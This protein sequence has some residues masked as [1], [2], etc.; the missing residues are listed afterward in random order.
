MS[1]AI[2]CVLFLIILTPLHA[3]GQSSISSEF[4]SVQDILADPPTVV[5]VAHESTLEGFGCR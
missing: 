4:D 1:R 3:L 2:S 5:H